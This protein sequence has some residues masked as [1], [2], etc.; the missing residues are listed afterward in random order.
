MKALEVLKTAAM[1][2]DIPLTHIGVELGMSRQYVH[3]SLG[4]NS[5]PKADTLARMLGVC[6]YALCAV[7]LDSVPVDALVIE[8]DTRDDSE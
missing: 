7:P 8:A 2:A 1:K 3:T 6:G 4:R 5:T